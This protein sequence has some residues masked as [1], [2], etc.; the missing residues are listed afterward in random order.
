MFIAHG[1]GKGGE[2]SLQ[3]RVLGVL[4]EFCLVRIPDRAIVVVVI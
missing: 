2:H 4:R 1:R 3:L